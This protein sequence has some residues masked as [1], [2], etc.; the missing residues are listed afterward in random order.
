MRCWTPGGGGTWQPYQPYTVGAQVTSSGLTYACQI[1][2]TSLPGWEP[3][4]T[5][6]LWRRL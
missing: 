3:P 5:P 1:A 2:H 6:A 4:N